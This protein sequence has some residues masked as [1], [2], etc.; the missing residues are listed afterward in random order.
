MC[1]RVR[2]VGGWS[3]DGCMFVYLMAYGIG[4]HIMIALYLRHSILTK[5]N[6]CRYNQYSLEYVYVCRTGSCA[7]FFGNIFSRL[8]VVKVNSVVLRANILL[9]E[10]V[11]RV[12]NGRLLALQPL[13]WPYNMVIYVLTVQPKL[14]ACSFLL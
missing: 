5:R 10:S 4:L 11:R 3:Y 12:E 8:L 6:A 1:R 14:P 2:R 9:R 13:I 7:L